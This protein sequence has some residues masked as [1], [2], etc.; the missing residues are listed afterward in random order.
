[1]NKERFLFPGRGDGCYH[2][3]RNNIQLIMETSLVKAYFARQQV[4]DH[5]SRATARIGL[6]RSEEKLFTQLFKPTDSLLEVGTGTG[7]IALALWELGY[8]RILGID[9][10]KEMI[11]QA[12][13]MAMVLE[14][15]VPFQ[16]MDAT[17]MGFGANVFDGAIFGFN[18]LMQIPKRANRRKALEQIQAALVS[19]GYF[20]FTTHDR[21]L[22]SRAAFWAEE[23]AR[24]D[25]GEQNP[26]IDE[27]GDRYEPTELGEL[28]IHIPNRQEVL[29][30][31]EATGWEYVEDHLRCEIANEPQEVRDFADECRFWI[32]R[33]KG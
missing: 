20:V 9:I 23:K 31:L 13:Q 2:T 15:G 30:D 7:R 33:K 24:W 18:G 3:A 11:A 4:V 17:R 29:E 12:R 32:A 27:F 19:G 21:D 14:Y 22:A 1:M 28:F 8:E 6:W 5:Y 25:A 10:S 26:L 16:V